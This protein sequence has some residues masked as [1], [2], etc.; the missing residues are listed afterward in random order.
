MGRNEGPHWKGLKVSGRPLTFSLPRL[1]LL[2]EEFGKQ[3][4]L[5]VF[6]I[7]EACGGWAALMGAMMDRL[8]AAH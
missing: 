2:N 1:G 7:I 5:C 8:N 3:Y 6:M 4:Y